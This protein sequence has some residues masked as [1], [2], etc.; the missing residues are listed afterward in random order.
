M[1][2]V[3]VAK[4]HGE[5]ITQIGKGERVLKGYIATF[6][7]PDASAP[8][9]MIKGKLLMPFLKK[10]DVNAIA[11]YSWHLDEIAPESGHAFDP[12]ELPVIFQSIAQLQ[13][14]CRRHKLQIDVTTY[15][16]LELARQH[17]L[18]AKEDPDAFQ[19][20]SKKYASKIELDRELE[21]LNKGFEGIGVATNVIEID[22]GTGVPK[23]K[24]PDVKVKQDAGDDDALLR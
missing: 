18:M 21:M 11:P 5:Y 4:V 14:Y 13:E 1:K 7:L 3:Y 10:L 22:S 15:A 12:D 17:V 16:D 8:L 19:V 2:K 9:G 20:I 6:R 23:A 24:R